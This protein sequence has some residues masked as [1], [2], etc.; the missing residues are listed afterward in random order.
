MNTN[1]APNMLG[2]RIRECAA[3]VGSGNELSRL[4]GIPRG[5][6]ERYMKGREPRAAQLAAIA[7]AAD[8][9]MDWLI[10]GE[11]EKQPIQSSKII[12]SPSID[13]E[14][15]ARVIDAIAK[16]YK[17]EGVHLPDVELGRLS[18]DK[19]KEIIES[20]VLP[21]DYPAALAMAVANLRKQ[22]RTAAA[23]PAKSKRRASE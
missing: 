19:Y 13:R 16:L 4:S 23:D 1:D 21:E 14:M 22:L 11:G 18:V 8:V 7:R 15:F 12:S 10:T 17:S 3:I 2:D 5:T 9:S 20:G 6:L